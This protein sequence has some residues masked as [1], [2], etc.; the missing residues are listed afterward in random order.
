MDLVR[1]I[2]DFGDDP[3]WRYRFYVCG[4][5]GNDIC[6]KA[7]LSE[8]A[9]INAEFN[10][11]TADRWNCPYDKIYCEAISGSVWG[12]SASDESE[13]RTAF[14]I[15]RTRL[16]GIRENAESDYTRLGKLYNAAGL[17]AGLMIVI[18]LF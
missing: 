13:R 16:I 4:N 1:T 14:S 17:L 15:I 6:R 9:G 12:I 18:L 11:G 7:D 3:D 8:P 5:Y 10:I 2:G